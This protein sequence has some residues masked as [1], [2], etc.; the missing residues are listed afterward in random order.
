MQK[1]CRMNSI[2]DVQTAVIALY[3]PGDETIFTF[4]RGKKVMK[5]KIKFNVIK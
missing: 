4:Q 3:D 2:W 1:D 5:I